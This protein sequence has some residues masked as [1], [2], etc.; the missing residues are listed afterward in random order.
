MPGGEQPDRQSESL[1]DI[2]KRVPSLPQPKTY[3]EWSGIR[4]MTLLLA[5]ICLVTGVFLIVWGVTRPALEDVKA[6]I[7]VTGAGD[8]TGA[9][10]TP[11][12]AA[13]LL[14][15]LQSK[16]FEH[17]RDIFQI[18]V[19]SALVPL[20]TLMAGYVFGRGRAEQTAADGAEE[21]QG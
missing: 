8:Q 20:F 18:A 11:E 2:I 15:S 12:K 7:A 17:F 5:F 13:E 1:A 3:L 6:M 10:L 21:T 9:P 14:E 16:H 4:Q 19:L